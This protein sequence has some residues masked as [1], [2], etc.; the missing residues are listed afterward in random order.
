LLAIAFTGA[1]LALAQA[2]QI[3]CHLPFANPLQKTICSD[4]Q[5]KW[6]ERKLSDIFDML[7]TLLDGSGRNAL[8]AEQ[9]TWEQQRLETCGSLAEREIVTCLDR[10]TDERLKKVETLLAQEQDKTVGTIVVLDRKLDI[11]HM[12]EDGDPRPSWMRLVYRDRTLAESVRPFEVLARHGNNRAEIVIVRGW[13]YKDP[14]ILAIVGRAGGEP[15]EV[16][17][18]FGARDSTR[19]SVDQSGLLISDPNGLKI[20]WSPGEGWQTIARP[21]T[22]EPLQPP[23]EVPAAATDEAPTAGHTEDKTILRLGGMDFVESWN[24][25]Q[26]RGRHLVLRAGGTFIMDGWTHFDVTGPERIGDTEIAFVTRPDGGTSACHSDFLFAAM[27]GQRLRIWTEPN[28]GG[29]MNFGLSRQRATD[30]YYLTMPAQPSRDGVRYRWTPRDGLSVDGPV[31]F[32]PPNDGTMADFIKPHPAN[33][34]YDFH[35]EGPLFN[36]E[37]YRAFER[38]AGPSLQRLAAYLDPSGTLL[39]A[40]DDNPEF[41]VFSECDAFRVCNV[42]RDSILA[43]YQV[44]TQQFYLAAGV[45][46]GPCGQYGINPPPSFERLKRYPVEYHPPLEKWSL[47]AQEALWQWY[48]RPH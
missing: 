39:T 3:D 43:I 17:L 30:G 48:C 12:V 21:S 42:P 18:D 37:F 25:D 14:Q 47:G 15:P 11:K 20:R 29:C 38:A 16:W 6:D 9:R 22:A 5:R 10:F 1:S 27:P 7:A 33:S 35:Y 44:S 36:S 4:N 24:T 13:P 32:T 26:N 8:L 41:V 45:G 19:Y 31:T 23:I 40:Y 2:K 46:E 28:G 34:G